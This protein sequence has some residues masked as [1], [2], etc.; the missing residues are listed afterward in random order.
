MVDSAV[1]DEIDLQI[2]HALH[3]DGRVPFADVA[4]LVGVSARTLTRRYGHLRSTGAVRVVGVADPRALDLIDWLVRLRG[5]PAACRRTADALA[6]RDDVRWVGLAS[7]GTEVTAVVRVSAG[8]APLTPTMPGARGVTAVTAVTAQCLLRPLAGVGGWPGH[9]HALPEDGA[10]GLARPTPPRPAA[11]RLDDPELR[12]LAAL[13]R[14]GRAPAPA[15]ASVT[16]WSE[17]SVRRRLDRLRDEG[18]LR[19]EV[20]VEPR[21]VGMGCEA[22]LWLGVTPSRIPQV[23]KAL[24]EHPAVAFAASTS[25]ATNVVAFVL[26]A[27]IDGLHDLLVGGL[28]VMTGI[29][30]VDTAPIA[31]H[32]KRAGALVLP[33]VA[34][35][36]PL[37]P[38][39]R[40]RE[41]TRG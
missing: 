24:D 16:G 30:R 15:L 34:G 31:R 23:A 17:S 2:V 27:D 6:R 26:C 40:M 22:V 32:V 5:D 18:V 8:V 13:A 3:L 4:P 29:D 38:S 1:L 36:A 21:A 12:L 20:D 7:G 41:G 19:F 35:S 11:R 14:D 9:R 28:G 33:P 37:T 25:G 10:A 39:S